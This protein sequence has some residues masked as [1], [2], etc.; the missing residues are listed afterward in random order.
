M[1]S[2]VTRLIDWLEWVSN[3]ILAGRF[4]EQP[5]RGLRGSSD[6]NL[7]HKLKFQ[8]LAEV[9][10]NRLGLTW[11]RRNGADGTDMTVVRPFYVLP[12]RR[13]PAENK[14]ALVTRRGGR[15]GDVQ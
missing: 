8:R 5:G 9:F 12:L 13:W 10:P 2:S 11:F 7:I 6:A 1:I 3:G 15:R 14:R 4:F